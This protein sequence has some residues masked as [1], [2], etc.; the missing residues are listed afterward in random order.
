MASINPWNRW[1]K[2][3]RSLYSPGSSTMAS[4]KSPGLETPS[5]MMNIINAVDLG[6][7]AMDDMQEALNGSFDAAGIESAKEKI[8]SCSAVPW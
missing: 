1:T 7:S 5:P 4:S 2:L 8:S 3:A 6:V